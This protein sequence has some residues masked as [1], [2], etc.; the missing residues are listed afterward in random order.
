[1]ILTTFPGS[2]RLGI[3]APLPEK[4]ADGSWNRTELSSND[5]LRKQL[6]GRN[7]DKVMKA[8]AANQGSPLNKG[9]AA[10]AQSTN[11]TTASANHDAESEDDEEG[12]TALVGKKRR[13]VGV[14]KAAKQGLE[15]DSPGEGQDGAPAGKDVP[16]R[17]APSKGRKK[18]T[19][20]L[21]EILAQ[22][23]SKKKKK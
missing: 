22:R 18:A 14:T 10:P 16:V 11:N 7:Y 15:Q 13:R 9:A 1:M 8:S 23:A 20:Y 17:Q 3:G 6:L 19:S 21:D 5:K 12:R 2:A 4:A